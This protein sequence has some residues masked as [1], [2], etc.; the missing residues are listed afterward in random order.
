MLLHLW[1][2]TNYIY[3]DR[4][5]TDSITKFSLSKLVWQQELIH[6]F[7][8][9]LKHEII[10]NQSYVF[11]AVL[12]FHVNFE[13]RKIY[14]FDSKQ[15]ILETNTCCIFDFLKKYRDFKHIQPFFEQIYIIDAKQCVFKANV[16]FI[17]G[18]FQK[19]LGFKLF[20]RLFQQI[21]VDSKQ[22]I[23]QATAYRVFG[24]FNK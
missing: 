8:L 1:R 10:Y 21:Y 22:R 16:Y 17:F 20:Q 11:D 23:F 19:Q 2:A 18:L 7:G 12:S 13:L 5:Q 9:L 3:R 15:C 4:P 6:S 24:L 14:V